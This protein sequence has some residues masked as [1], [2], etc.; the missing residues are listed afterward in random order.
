M[1]A[2][3]RELASQGKAVFLSSHQLN[4][5]QQICD[6]VAIV[7]GGRVVVDG[8]VTALLREQRETRVTV[9]DPGA[10]ERVLGDQPWVNEVRVDGDALVVRGAAPSPFAAGE[11]LARAGVWVSHLSHYEG[12]LERLFLEVTSVRV[13]EN[14]RGGR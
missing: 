9:S 10:A 8:P 7:F 1:R 11:A 14:K 3:L 5:V 12:T 6:R 4:E 13:E 2:L